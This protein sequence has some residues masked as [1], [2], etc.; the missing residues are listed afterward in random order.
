MFTSQKFNILIE[1]VNRSSL[2]LQVGELQRLV[3][4][5]PLDKTI[6][7]NETQFSHISLTVSAINSLFYVNYN[8]IIK[9]Q[10]DGQSLT[11]LYSNWSIH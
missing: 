9:G 5:C 8:W 7:C 2:L 3:H 10:N 11:V 6:F 4:P 1:I